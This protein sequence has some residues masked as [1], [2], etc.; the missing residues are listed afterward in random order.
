L[1]EQEIDRILSFAVRN[2]SEISLCL[3]FTLG[4]DSIDWISSQE[5]QADP[6]FKHPQKNKTPQ[7]PEELKGIP[8]SPGII[9]GT[10]SSTPS[11]IDEAAGKILICEFLKL[12]DSQ[13]LKLLKGI[14]LENGSMLSHVGILAREW[15]IPCIMGVRGASS[16]KNGEIIKLDA[17]KGTV[18]RVL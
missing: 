15:G 17:I 2:S 9:T 7:W 1:S 12:K 14:I 6:L 8:C 13:N 10:A 4:I 11:L 5:V 16:I 3:H 18:S